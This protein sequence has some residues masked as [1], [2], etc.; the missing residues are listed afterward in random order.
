[1]G[2]GIKPNGI[3]LRSLDPR[4][5]QESGDL[6]SQFLLISVTF[7]HRCLIKMAI[8]SPDRPVEMGL[9]Q[10]LGSA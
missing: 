9:L 4:I 3:Y 6:G 7:T 10:S 8:I 5:L 1:M 2:K